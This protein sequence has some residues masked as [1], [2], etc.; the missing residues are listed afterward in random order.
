[1]CALAILAARRRY[2]EFAGLALA[3]ALVI[4][5]ALGVGDLTRSMAY[6]LPAVFVALHV[7]AKNETPGTVERM[8]LAAALVCALLPTWFVQSGDATWILPFPVQLIRLF[9]YPRLG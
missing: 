3:I 2:F 6:A 4:A 1:M 9:V 7:L 5:G 8:T